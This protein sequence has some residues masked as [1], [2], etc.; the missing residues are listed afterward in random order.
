MILNRNK[1]E[2][3]T[4]LSVNNDIYRIITAFNKSDD[5]K[6]LLVHTNTKPLQGESLVDVDMRDKQISRVTLLPYDE[7]EGSIVNVTLI[8]GTM[9]HESNT[10]AGTL[11]I[12]VFTPGNQWIINE[13]VR[14]LVIAHYI[15]NIMLRDFNQTDG[16]KYRLTDIINAQLSD[17]LIGY[18][19]IYT[20]V[21]DD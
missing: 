8:N 3:D 12:D 10:L 4:F 17:I 9:E 5:L 19:L 1:N 6:K 16:V 13:G 11:A 14:P 20:A 7:E 18:R 15:N 2:V 21:I